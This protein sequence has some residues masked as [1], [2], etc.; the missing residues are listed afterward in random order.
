MCVKGGGGESASF[1]MVEIKEI[2]FAN[3]K[4]LVFL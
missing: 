3:I 1:K 2:Y 4:A